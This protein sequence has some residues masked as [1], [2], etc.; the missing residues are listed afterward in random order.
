MDKNYSMVPTRFFIIDTA[1]SIFLCFSFRNAKSNPN[2]VNA[3][4]EQSTVSFMK[5]DERVM[6][7]HYIN[8]AKN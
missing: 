1:S 4:N 7:N 8:P 3:S 2:S 6:A 5:H